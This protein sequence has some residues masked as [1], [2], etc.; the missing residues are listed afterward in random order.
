MLDFDDKGSKHSRRPVPDELRALL[1]A[2]ID[3]G[4][5]VDPDDYLIPPEGL[6]TR[7]GERDDRVI[8]RLVSRVAARAGVRCHVHALRAAFATYYLEQNPERLVSLQT[9]MGHESISTTQVYLRKLNRRDQ[10]EQVRDLR[11]SDVGALDTERD[12]VLRP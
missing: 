2:A 5:V 10:M 7:Q 3:S 6:L 4:L 9:L 11:W 8:W 1:D 12:A